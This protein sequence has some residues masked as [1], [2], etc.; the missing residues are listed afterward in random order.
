[1]NI[2]FAL[3]CCIAALCLVF[4]PAAM[5]QRVDMAHSE[6]SFVTRQMGVPVEGRFTRWDA[7]LAFDPRQPESGQATLRI[8][9]GSA[10]FAAPEVTAEAQRPVWLDSARFP[11]ATFQSTAIKTLGG[12]RYEMTGRL[13][14]KGQTQELVLPITLAQ[15]GADGVATGS[16]AVNRLV[17][18]IGE[19]EWA[20][21][22]LVAPEVQVKF[23]LALTGL[24]AR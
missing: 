13:S 17:F 1:M 24:P 22:S 8:E 7:A 4:V 20:D 14:L 2:A 12:G 10:R 3:R 19:G 23:K 5:A 6:L 11:L 9:L 15:T 18:R 16:F 21:A